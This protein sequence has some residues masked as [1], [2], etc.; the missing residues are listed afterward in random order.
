MYE[1]DLDDLAMVAACHH[2]LFL[3]AREKGDTAAAESIV[4]ISAASMVVLCAAAGIADVAVMAKA[5]ELLAKTSSDPVKL[6]H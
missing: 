2:R 3:R 1:K 6:V 5:T 4:N